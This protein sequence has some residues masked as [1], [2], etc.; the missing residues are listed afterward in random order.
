[1]TSGGP[2]VVAAGITGEGRP[3]SAFHP[4]PTITG[5]G[6]AYWL[7]DAAHWLGAP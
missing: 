3:R 1:M 2:Y 6:T 7:A 4:A 5:K